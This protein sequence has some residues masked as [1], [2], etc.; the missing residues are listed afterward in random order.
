MNNTY[1]HKIAAAVIEAAEKKCNELDTTKLSPD[2]RH[3]V[4]ACAVAIRSLDRDSI[5][6]SV[7]KEATPEELAQY[8]NGFLS[9]GEYAAR[10]KGTDK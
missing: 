5:I 7:P 8:V 9:A 4:R 2:G 3:D 1:A 6:A 10:L